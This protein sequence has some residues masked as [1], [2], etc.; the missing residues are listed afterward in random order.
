VSDRVQIGDATLYHG[1]CLEILP[2]LDKVD[3]VVTDP[4]YGIGLWNDRSKTDGTRFKSNEFSW[5]KRPTADLIRSIIGLSNKS[6]FFGFNHL[7]NLM[8]PTKKVLVWD[9][10][11]RGLH[12]NDCELAAAYG[13]GEACRVF[14]Y[15]P[16]SAERKQH[17][18]EKPI[19]VMDW[20]LSHV[21]N[22]P[23][24]LD[25]FMGSGTTGVACANLGRKFI[26]IEI[27]RK[28][29]DIAVERIT[30][31]YAQGRLFV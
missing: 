11:F 23:L 30:A 29:F 28:Y 18:T 3:A 25:P 21:G 22:A 31:A 17:P 10:G 5:D 14:N 9:K 12:F 19:V 2:T 24:I 13:C 7:S 6:V 8:P 27:E 15:A 16:A 1:D 26:G 4:P 20:V